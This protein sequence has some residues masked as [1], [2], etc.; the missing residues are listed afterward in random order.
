[1]N[2]SDYKT[3]IQNLYNYVDNHL[4]ANN[5]I[6][7]HQSLLCH[8]QAF[9]YLQLDLATLTFH[10]HSYLLSLPNLNVEN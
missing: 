8:Y 6:H 4:F 9:Q 3:D 5:P 7:G 2:Q 1:M 10:Y